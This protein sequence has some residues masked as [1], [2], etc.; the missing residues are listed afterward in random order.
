MEAFIKQYSISLWCI[1]Q[2]THGIAF[3]VVEF[4]TCILKLWSTHSEWFLP[5]IWS[6]TARMIVLKRGQIHGTS[7]RYSLR[8]IPPDFYQYE[9]WEKIL[10]LDKDKKTA[11]II[12]SSDFWR[13]FLRNFC[14]NKSEQSGSS[15]NVQCIGLVKEKLCLTNTS[16]KRLSKV[17]P[18]LSNNWYVHHVAQYGWFFWG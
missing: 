18:L 14:L 1:R 13:N 12:N 17:L 6:K 16:L 10:T 3:F 5:R 7:Y 9:V 11:F 2:L 8:I 4:L 15:A